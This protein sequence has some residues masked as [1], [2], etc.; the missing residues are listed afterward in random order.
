[1]RVLLVEDEVHLSEALEYMLKKNNYAVDVSFDGESA[2]DN[3]LTGIYDAIILDVMIPKMSGFEVLK[4]MRENDIWTPVIMLTAMSEVDNRV[5]GLDLGA[6]DYLAKPFETSEL[7]SRLKVITRRCGNVI[8]SDEIN[9]LNVTYNRSNLTINCEGKS[10]NLTG[11]ESELF[12]LLIINA[13]NVISKDLIIEK[14][15]GFDSDAI[16]NN[17]E[18]YISFLR[19]KI[20]SLDTDLYIKTIRGIG[21]ILGGK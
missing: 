14:L 13:G 17:V 4:N 12:E 9:Y 5:K 10:F 21:Y 8:V 18:V 15:W 2:L 16:D 11:K 7:L 1:M 3:A 19:K 20:S 6:D